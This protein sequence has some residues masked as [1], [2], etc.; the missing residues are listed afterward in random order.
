MPKI[1]V[2]Y[3][4]FGQGHKTAAQALGDSLGVGAFDLLDFCLPLIAR[5]YSW[6]YIFITNHFP[7]LWQLIF[8]SSKS[9]LASRMINRLHRILFASFF[10]HLEA[11]QPQIVIT[12]HFFPADLVI[13][14]KPQINCRLIS[15]ITDIRVHPLWVNSEIDHYFAALELTKNDL[16]SLGVGP[17]K[18]TSGFMPLRQGFRKDLSRQDLCRKFNLGPKP[19]I[20]FVC[21]S[22]GVFPCLEESLDILLKDF[23]VLVIYGQ[24]ERLRRYLESLESEN[25]RYFP[26][27]ERIW[28]LIF[29]S[30]VIVTKP[31][32]MTIFETAYYNKPFIFT[33]YIPGQEKANMDVLISAGVAQFVQGKK[34]L[35]KAVSFFTQADK[36]LSENYPLTVDH[37]QPA[38]TRVIG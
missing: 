1:T 6:G 15:I 12:T 33:H 29:L 16:I 5:I 24:N 11:E 9:K 31:G 21:S 3:A 2:F 28:E 22:R 36:Q 7:Y 26:F 20:L 13:V 30:S 32:G 25:L 10:A 17:E 27:Y 37:I 34:D 8:S 35:I 19:T 23:N 4:S 18:I 14:A 38:L